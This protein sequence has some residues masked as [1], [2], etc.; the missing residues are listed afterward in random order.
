M[1]RVFFDGCVA[2]MSDSGAERMVNNYAAG[3]GLGAAVQFFLG[4]EVHS[5]PFWGPDQAEMNRHIRETVS[6][7]QP[8]A[9]VVEK[10]LS[11][12]AAKK[13]LHPF[14]FDSDEPRHQ[15][16]CASAPVT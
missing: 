7:R 5:T 16:G 12:I 9:W 8:W 3:H 15:A 13:L 14:M 10:L 11:E 2:S 4:L 1:V 6:D